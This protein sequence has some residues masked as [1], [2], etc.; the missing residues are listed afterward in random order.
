[1]NTPELGTPS[2]QPSMPSRGRRGT[3]EGPNRRQ[4]HGD[5]TATRVPLPRPKVDTEAQ[6]W[7]GVEITS[8]CLGRFLS[9]SRG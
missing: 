8:H 7:T 2:Q 5:A 9:S 3:T 1:M 4:H 6:G